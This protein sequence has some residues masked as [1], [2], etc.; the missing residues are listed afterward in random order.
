MNVHRSKIYLKDINILRN[1]V[2][3]YLKIN[4]KNDFT[5]WISQKYLKNILTRP[6]NVA[7]NIFFDVHIVIFD[8]LYSKY[9]NKNS[10]SKKQ[11]IEST[12]QPRQ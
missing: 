1:K 8:V 6:M 12:Q 2:W 9:E 11:F 4:K 7:I 10:K 3:I 5:A